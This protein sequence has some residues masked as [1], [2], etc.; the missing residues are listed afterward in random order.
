MKGEVKYVVYQSESGK[1][2]FKLMASDGELLAQSGQSYE[3]EEGCKN[4]VAALKK[5]SDS[6][7]DDLTAGKRNKVFIAHGRN[8]REALLLQKYLRDQLKIDAFVF[9]DLPDKGRTIIEQL[10][11]IKERVWYAFAIGMAED[12]GCLGTGINAIRRVLMRSL[13][14]RTRQNV[15]FEL[16]LLI[17]ALGRENVCCLLQENVEEKPSDIDGILYK[18][19]SRSVDEKFHE[20][21]RE[22]RDRGS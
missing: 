11:F 20:I 21:E 14:T 7:I 10:E 4:A 2:R 19:F 17:G 18:S 15:V 1:Y 13:R 8:D 5:Y 22:I 12:S 16:G 9:D 6:P 3:T